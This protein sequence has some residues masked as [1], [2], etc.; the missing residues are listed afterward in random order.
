MK[1]FLKVITSGYF[2]LQFAIALILI[3]LVIFIA[4]SSLKKYTRHDQELIVPAV[5]N[6]Y[7]YDLEDSEYSKELNFVIS[8]SIYNALYEQGLIISQDP[9]AGSKVKPNR[10]IYLTIAASSPG[11]VAMPD[12]INLS[13]R[14]A[15]GIIES[16][17]L[18][19]GVMEFVPS[20]D[21]N[22]VLQQRYQGVNIDKG[23][24]ITKG[25]V[26]D[27][28]V[29]AGFDKPVINLPN[30]LGKNVTEA[31]YILQNMSLNI[32]EEYFRDSYAINEVFVYKTEPHWSDTTMVQ[33]GEFIDLYYTA[34]TTFLRT[35]IEEALLQSGELSPE[36]LDD[37]D[38][39]NFDDL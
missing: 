11:E 10:K 34:D 18:K 20:F 17:G 27:I 37:E 12:L 2:W 36:Y 32:G 14:Q 23:T 33:L 9:K 30:I 19:F 1:R 7:Y 8:D 25:S 16:S 24:M 21:K 5:E 4:K 22:A 13:V 38:F 3:L 39:E 28:V 15:I 29:G 26:I 6:V 31:K 35:S